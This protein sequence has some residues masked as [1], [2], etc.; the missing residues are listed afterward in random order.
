MFADVRRL[1][2]IGRV[3][4]G[5]SAVVGFGPVILGPPDKVYPAVR[6]SSFWFRRWG[7]GIVAVLISAPFLVEIKGQR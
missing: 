5:A 1:R 2:D 7:A 4:A 3:S 6:C